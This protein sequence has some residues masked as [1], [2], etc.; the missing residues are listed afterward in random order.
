M[1]HLTV[2]EI[3][4]ISAGTRDEV[5]DNFGTLAAVMFYSGAI[6]EV[7]FMGVCGYKMAVAPGIPGYVGTVIGEL[8]IPATIVVMNKINHMNKQEV[9]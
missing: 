7:I 1:R 8:M 9:L 6:A 2:L 3:S 5:R 4:N